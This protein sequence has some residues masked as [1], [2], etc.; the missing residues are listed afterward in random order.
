MWFTHMNDLE[1]YFIENEKRV[2][3]KWTH[4]F[5]IY[6]RYFSRYR[7]KKPIILEIGV[8]SGGSLQMWKDYFGKDTQIYGVDIDAK[9]KMVEE[10]NINIFI[11]SQ[12]DRV[13]LNEI[14]TL[15]PK[16]DILIDDG[17]HRMD[18]QIITFEELFDHIK[19]DGV[20]LIEDLHT[21]YWP[22]FDGG[23]KRNNTFIEYSKNF[24][25]HLNANHIN[26]AS[27]FTKSVNSIHYY[28]SVLVIEKRKREIP[29]IVTS[30]K[31]Y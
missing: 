19:D 29:F 16:V 27:N 23:Y 8:A 12:S 9:S 22:E 26:C 5:E 25:D 13:F 11:G 6:D 7:N 31:I 1:K 10:E 17:G 15:I 30:G 24:I 21:S 3:G 14:K 18:Q 2:M 4:Y 28:D 20:Y